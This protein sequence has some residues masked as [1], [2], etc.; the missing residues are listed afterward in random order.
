MEW[1]LISG[2]GILYFAGSL[3]SKPPSQ[4]LIKKLFT[5]ETAAAAPASKLAAG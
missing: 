3:I 4:E 2:C 1:I 5:K